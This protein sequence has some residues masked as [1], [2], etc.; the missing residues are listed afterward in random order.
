[1]KKKIKKIISKIF[2]K[3]IAKEKNQ[4]ILLLHQ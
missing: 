3:G 2:P 1:M 4:I